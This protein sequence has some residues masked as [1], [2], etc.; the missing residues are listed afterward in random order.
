MNN[1]YD[2]NFNYEILYSDLFYNIGIKCKFYGKY[3]IKIKENIT[4]EI[5]KNVDSKIKNLFSYVLSEL[6]KKNIS[7]LE[8]I[9]KT[10]EFFKFISNNINNVDYIINLEYFNLASV[11]PT[12]DYV[13]LLKDKLD[14]SCTTCGAMLKDVSLFCPKCGRRVKFI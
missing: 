6:S 5:I 11:V 2:Y 3:T 7:Y 12:S 9:D 13:E 1:I 8:V 10:D 14:N 4:D